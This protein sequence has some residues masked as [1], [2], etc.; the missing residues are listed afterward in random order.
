MEILTA[1]LDLLEDDPANPRA[2]PRENVDAIKASLGRFGQVLPILVRD[3]DCRIVAGNGT[4][5]AMRELGWT[6]CKVAIYDGDD[7]EC[8]ALSIALNRTAELADWHEDNLAAGIAE[9]RAGGFEALGALGFGA[10]L[11]QLTS[12]FRHVEFDA[13]I[14]DDGKP[15]DG[16]YA[17][18]EV[19]EPPAEP[20][21]RW[22]DVWT[23]GRHRL[24]CGDC[25]GI[26]WVRMATSGAA[27]NVAITS[28][29][30]AAQR[31]YDENSEFEPIQPEHYVAWFELVQS[32]IAQVLALDGSFFLNIK[33]HCE[34]GQRVLYVKDLTLAHVRLW[35]WRFVDELCWERPGLPGRY[36]GRFKNAWEPVF[37]FSR[38]K[39]FKFRPLAVAHPS[40]AVPVYSYETDLSPVGSL[41]GLFN[42]RDQSRKRAENRE[43]RS[44]LALP[45]NRLP[46]FSTEGTTHE[47]AFPVGLPTFFLRA[48]SDEGDTCYDPFLGSGT[49]LI[50]A[51]KLDRVCFGIEISPR[52]CD[53]IV[54][55]WQNLTGGGAVRNG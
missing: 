11:E 13:R 42:D 1:Y 19:P 35:G 22:G 15:E 23:L 54:E 40:D 17:E 24:V 26:D 18:D 14:G 6:E 47:A 27:V 37:H 55:R 43:I 33:E 12:Q 39:G 20:V 50:A 38:E 8:R 16:L 30:Y 3:S 52:Y 4:V 44:G 31:K 28:P 9:L 10:N 21:T 25:R 29:P 5:A 7:A 46:P 51:E 49:T 2:H 34:D 41:T 53:V 36:Q 45:S 32:C 48:Y